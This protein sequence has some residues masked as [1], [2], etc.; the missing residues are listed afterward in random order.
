VFR[1]TIAVDDDYLFTVTDQVQNNTAGEISL[2]PF[3]LISRHG[4][5]P[6]SG[7]YI[8][9]EGPIGVMGDAGLQELSYADLL[10][11]GGTKTYKQTGGWLGMT[12]KYWAAALIPPQK[13]AYDA[14]VSGIKGTREYFQ[15]DFLMAGIAVPPGGQGASTSSLFA[16]A[17]QVALLEAYEEKLQAKNFKLLIDWGWFWFI[18]QP[19][20]KLLHWLSQALGNYGLAILATTVLVKAAFFPL[21]NKSY[22][23]MA[24]MKKLQPEMEKIRE[25]FK[26]DRVKQQQEL[27]ALYKNEKINPMAGCL[28]IALQIPVFFALYKVLF[29]TIDMRQAPFFGWIK[30]LSS[31]DPTSLFN[32]FGLLPYHVPDMLH[33]GAWPLVMGMTMWVQMQLNPQQPDPVQQ[34]IFNWMPV[35][36]TFMLASFPSGLVI[37]WAWNNVLSLLQQYTIMRRNNTE[38]HLWK[39]LGADKWKARLAAAKGLDAGKIKGH[40]AN[41]SSRLPQS[42]SKVLQRGDGKDAKGAKDGKSGKVGAARAANEARRETMTR[43]QALRTLGLETDASDKDIDAALAEQELKRRQGA[44]NGSDHA[45]AARI[46]AARDILRGKEGS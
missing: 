30:D 42:L 38:V 37:Y 20:Y 18:T 39:N 22:E 24:K 21:A 7:Y 16:G 32:L 6:T 4:T 5:P 44:L 36:F 33:V 9:H 23:S 29:V 26:E 19:L 31:P 41:V 34:K 27:M 1:R 11:D 46:D 14:K 17:K 13:T 10:K 25:R 45:I 43:E 40:L 8:L 28:P 15:T 12:D 2:H 35:I 3:A